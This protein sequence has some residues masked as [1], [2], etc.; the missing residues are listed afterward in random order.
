MPFEFGMLPDGAKLVQGMYL[1][2][3]NAGSNVFNDKD[4]DATKIKFN[5]SGDS[6]THTFDV[7]KTQDKLNSEL[8]SL[9]AAGIGKGGVVRR[10][11]SVRIKK[12]VKT[13][14][15]VASFVP[16]LGRLN[17][18]NVRKLGLGPGGIGGLVALARGTGTVVEKLAPHVDR[19]V[20]YIY[21]DEID[22]KNKFGQ[23]KEPVP[24]IIRMETIDDYQGENGETIWLD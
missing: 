23:V 5:L 19:N 21:E 22:G 10:S 11:T 12:A 13:G 15:K 20:R 2:K 8:R 18:E 7:V 6:K 24:S 16:M 4:D 3:S 9:H 14:A 17:P 1:R